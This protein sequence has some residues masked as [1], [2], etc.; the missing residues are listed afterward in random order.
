MNP[1]DSQVK[2]Q[3]TS[4][5]SDVG[6]G[7]TREDAD[8]LGRLTAMSEVL[9]FL[10]ARDL[11]DRTSAEAQAVADS[12]ISAE[13]NL[14]QGAGLMDVDRLQSV[15]LAAENTSAMIVTQALALADA[16]RDSRRN[17]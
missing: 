1:A 15:R 17:G 10:M 8:L 9:T 2:Q 6:T 13:R 4:H 7:M 14:M 12:L 16:W 5:E 11:V 3:G